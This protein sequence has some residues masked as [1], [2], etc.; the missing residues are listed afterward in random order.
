MADGDTFEVNPSHIAVIGMAGRFPEAEDLDGFWQNLAHGVESVKPV[1]V[2]EDV[3]HRP[4]FAELGDPD[5]FDS[6]YFGYAPREALIIDPQHRLF[7]EC[8]V[9]ALE[10]AGEDPERFPGPIGVYAGGS[11]TG[12]L[13]S[14]R[15]VRDRLGNP[16]EMML[17]FGT[18]VAFLTT[19]VAYQLGLRGPAVTVQTACSTSLV[20]VHQ[21]AQALLAGDCDMALAGGASV[22]VPTPVAEYTEDGAMSGDGH[23][24]AFDAAAGGSVGGDAVG[25]VVLKRLDDAVADGNTIHAVLIGTAV[26]NDGHEK[27]GFTAPSVSGQAEVMRTALKVAEVDPDTVSYVETHGTGTRLGDPIEVAALTAAYGPGRVADRPQGPIWIGSL[28]TNIGHSDAAAGVAGLIKTI[29]ALRHRLIPPSLNFATPNPEIDFENSPFRVNAE[30]REWES[31]GAP[32]RA[33]VNALGVGGTNAHVLL[34]EA[35]PVPRTKAEKPS[36]LVVVSAKSRPALSDAR[37]RLADHLEKHPATDLRDVAWT[38]QTGRQAHP[39][40]QAFVGSTVQDLVAR[41]ADTNSF[42]AE[43]VNGTDRSVAM[44]F[45]GHGGQKLGMARELYLHEGIFRA[46]LDACSA[47]FAP[48]LD[49]SLPDVLFGETSPS[50]GTDFAELPVA[51]AAIFSVEMALYRLWESWGITPDVVAGQSLGSYAAACVAGVFTLADAAAVVTCRSRLLETL[52]SGGM[53]AVSLPE[54]EVSR[55][56]TDGVSLGAVNGPDQCVLSGPTTAVVELAARLHKAGVDV[57]R[58]H[59]PGAGHSSLV[60]SITGRFADFMASVEFGRPVVPFVSDSDGRL[61]DPDRLA[62]PQYWVD[63]MRN[64]VRFGDVVSKLLESDNRT[65]L[66]VGPGRS[67]TTLVRRHP[68]LKKDHL[69]VSSLPHPSAPVSDL[70]HILGSAGSLWSAGHDLDWHGVHSGAAGRRIA[71]PTYPFQRTRFRLDLTAE[72][73]VQIERVAVADVDPEV[74]QEAPGTASEAAVARLFEEVLGVSRPARQHDFFKLGGDSL[75]ATQLTSRLRKDLSIRVSVREVFHAPT[76][77]ALAQLVDAKLASAS[78]GGKDAAASEGAALVPVPRAEGG[79]P[80]SFAQQR[81]WFLEQL[82][83]DGLDLS[84]PAMLR[85][86]GGLDV[87]ALET[88]FSALVARHEVLRTRFV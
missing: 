54:S 85:V 6:D 76:V 67:M 39:Y 8:A 27:I 34:E 38:T 32:R 30:L 7:M 43:P 42:P 46:S 1:P 11:Q 51:H 16:S 22:H 9:E 57:R 5:C 18:G 4:A 10:C 62:T 75:L 56:L 26:N 25:I 59:I 81:L 33:A 65:I 73:P 80:L 66:E 64:T 50:A 58:L 35:P 53:L 29:L 55:L 60:D 87:E 24:R 2:S 72:E 21:A 41:L 31:N 82:G 84:V 23:C 36:Q 44:V 19:R 86:R 17:G 45:P 71:L 49:V 14:L 12:H 15:A 77:A 47:A 37:T 79:L 78:A 74:L 83:L 68:D 52:P 63:H 70:E 48:H 28:K 13:E 40:R 61:M 88:A 69:V 3:S 20:A